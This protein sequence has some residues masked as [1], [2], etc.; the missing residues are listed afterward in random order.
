M[1][2]SVSALEGMS[3]SGI[4]DV[5][6]QGLQGM[7]T[8]R[9]D[10]S[11]SAFVA[12]L[13]EETGF[14]LPKPRKITQKKG[15]SLAWMSPD[16]LLLGITYEKAGDVAT[17]LGDA[18][19]AQHALVANV[20]DARVMFQVSG[21]AA[22]DVMAKVSPVDFS[23]PSFVKGQIRRTRI[24]QVSAAIWM[25]DQHSFRVIA[26][27]SVAKYVFDSLKDASKSGSEVGF[28]T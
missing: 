12:A 17:R 16:E 15:M 6:E 5:S 22:R 28:L 26:F 19:K 20:S 4:A 13:K 25:V 18:L 21:E 24:A 1:F 2:K 9:G 8:I 11:D 10:F 27:R 3:Y 14:S 7:V 23:A